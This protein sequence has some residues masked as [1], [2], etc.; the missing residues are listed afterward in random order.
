MDLLT[1]NNF[2]AYRGASWKSR[3][4]E[5]GL[6]ILTDLDKTMTCGDPLPE[7]RELKDRHKVRMLMEESGA[8]SAAVSARTPGLMMSSKELR[9]AQ[10]KGY[11][12]PEPRWGVDAHGKH[13][14]VPIEKEPFFEYC[15]DF[16]LLASFGEDIVVMQPDG[17]AVDS[18]YSELLRYGESEAQRR[19]RMQAAVD[20]VS[21][22]NLRQQYDK[23]GE[24]RAPSIGWRLDS[25]SLIATILPDARDFMH[26]IEFAEKYRQR[27]TNVAPLKARIQLHFEGEEGLQKIR[28]LEETLKEERKKKNP[29]A[30][31]VNLIDESKIFWGE[32]QKNKYTV[33][34]APDSARKENLIRRMIHGSA[35]AADRKPSS[36]TSVF[37]DD[38]ATGF[39]AINLV[40]YFLLPT[41]SPLAPFIVERRQSYG[42]HCFKFLWKNGVRSEDRLRSVKGE[43]GVYK[44]YRPGKKPTLVVIGDE[45][46][47]N[48]TPPGSQALFLEEFPLNKNAPC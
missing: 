6:L 31:R 1:A 24:D 21:N 27:L 40:D 35:A 10:A 13:V 39:K 42:S 43:R 29:I 41:G 15:H 5:R 8:V 45:R 28:K 25:L 32:P 38:A 14:F 17:Y 12:E 9:A 23:L 48:E 44:Y 22:Q 34:L 2:D 33:Y 46:Y 3:L 47:P 19:R 30:Y 4:Q 26:D 7:G 20:S 16:D 18:Y 37:S 36:I 11:A